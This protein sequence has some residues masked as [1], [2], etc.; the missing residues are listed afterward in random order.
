M[1]QR[2]LSSQQLTDLVTVMRAVLM[3]YDQA[4][5]VE[6]SGGTILRQLPD[7]V[8]QDPVWQTHIQD[9]YRRLIETI[10]TDVGLR[11][12][13]LL[14]MP[15]LVAYATVQQIAG[16]LGSDGKLSGALS[17]DPTLVRWAQGVEGPRA[18]GASRVQTIGLVAAAGLGGF[19]LARAAIAVRG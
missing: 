15:A 19:L 4:R 6:P 12:T 13:R 17:K 14:D 11:S 8:W 18:G 7:P 3:G 5:M 10:T 2:T 16:H 9:A 1:A